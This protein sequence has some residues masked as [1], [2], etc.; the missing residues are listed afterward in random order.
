[1]SFPLEFLTKEASEDLNQKI[2]QNA[3]L[4]YEGLTSSLLPSNHICRSKISV[5]TTP[6]LLEEDGSPKSDLECS[7]IIFKW[8]SSLTPVQASDGRLWTYLCHGPFSDYVHARWRLGLIG[9][10]NPHD[11]I[12][13]RWFFRGQGVATFVRNGIS[14]LWWFGHLTHDAKRNDPFELTSALLY[15]QDVQVA[16][17]ERAFG[18]C[19]PVLTAALESVSK[20]R[21]RLDSTSK[22]GP[23]FQAWAKDI[24]LYGGTYILDALPLDRLSDAVENRLV[25][26]IKAPP[27]E[28]SLSTDEAEDGFT[29]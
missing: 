8:L 28:Q 4:Y 25:Q 6:K 13:N 2:A 1:M 21:A 5:G 22:V 17:L 9:A 3:S 24:N 20:N 12:R 16:L 15:R 26:R 10:K 7:K 27:D 14:R 19:K 11:V 18:R 29:D 23:L